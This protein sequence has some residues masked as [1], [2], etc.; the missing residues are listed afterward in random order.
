MFFPIIDPDGNEV[1]PI[2]DNGEEACWAKGLAGVQKHIDDKTLGLEAEDQA[3]K[4]C[5]G[6]L[7][8]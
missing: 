3:W 8:A 1:F 2:H 4:S 7:H 5:L 6:T